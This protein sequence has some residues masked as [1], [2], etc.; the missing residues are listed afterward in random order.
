[1]SATQ[2][3]KTGTWG[4]DT[5]INPEDNIIFVPNRYIQKE[6]GATFHKKVNIIRY[7]LNLKTP[8]IHPGALSKTTRLIH[9]VI[10]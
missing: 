10:T 1:M 4:V 5:T 9:T 3:N 8:I 2:K 6:Y 7:S